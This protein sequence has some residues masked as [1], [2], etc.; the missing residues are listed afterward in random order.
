MTKSIAISPYFIECKYSYQTKYAI[1]ILMFYLISNE[2]KQNL[3]YKRKYARIS[4]QV[5][6]FLS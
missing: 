6:Y 1:I 2:R 5:T 3:V 4:Y